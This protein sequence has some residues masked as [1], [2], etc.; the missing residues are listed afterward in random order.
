[1]ADLLF[2]EKKCL[3]VRFEGVQRGFLSERKVKGN[4]S[5]NVE[6]PKTEKARKPTWKTLV[7]TTSALRLDAYDLS[8]KT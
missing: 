6:G 4:R 2:R 1:M 5:L 7:L 8:T 3:E